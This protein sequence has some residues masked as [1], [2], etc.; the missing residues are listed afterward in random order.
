MTVVFSIVVAHELLFTLSQLYPIAVLYSGS[1]ASTLLLLLHL[2]IKGILINGET[3][4]TANQLGEVEREAIGVEQ[5]ESLYTIQFG[6]SLC[7]QF[8]HGLVQH[9]DTL[10]ECTQEA[11]FLF[12]DNLG[13]QLLL[14]LQF[15]ECI[16]H[17]VY[18]SRNELIKESVLLSEEGVCVA[19]G[20][21]QDTTNHVTCL[22]IRWQLTISNREGYGTQVVCTYAHSHIDVVLLL[23]DRI[24]GLFLEGEVFQTSDILLCLDDRLEY[25]GIVVR[26]LAL[27]HA[28]Q[29]LKAHTGIDYVH[30][31][32]L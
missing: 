8:L 27:H 23:A 24:F 18:Q 16:A 11:V 29:A 25:V 7:L 21:T 15:G 14:S 9:R 26:V 19:Y 1:V 20:T 32:L 22:C 3:I 10:V 12:L 31:E 2:S 4:L 5:A 28:N 13:N 17:L 30:R 6:L